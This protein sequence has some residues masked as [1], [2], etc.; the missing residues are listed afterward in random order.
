ML[1]QK[2]FPGNGSKSSPTLDT[3]SRRDQS[4]LVSDKHFPTWCRHRPKLPLSYTS[5]VLRGA[6]IKQ[7]P[8]S[9]LSPFPLQNHL[10]DK[11]LHIHMSIIDCHWLSFCCHWDFLLAQLFEKD[12]KLQRGVG[13]GQEI[14][15]IPYSLLRGEKTMVWVLFVM[16]REMK[17]VVG[18][19]STVGKAGLIQ[20]CT[21]HMSASGSVFKI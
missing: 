9:S 14:E 12:Q 15:N 17:G 4:I 7:Q 11:I 21:S 8:M 16:Q 6:S 3:L 2:C 19:D 5:P 18:T 20:S 1:A 10:L 13:E